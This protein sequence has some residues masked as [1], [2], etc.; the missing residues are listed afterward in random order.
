MSQLQS[1]SA[2][3]II[4]QNG[5]LSKLRFRVYDIIYQFGPITIKD[6]HAKLKAGGPIEI[7]STSP[8]FIELVRLGVIE[9]SGVTQCPITGHNVALYSVTGRLP[10]KLPASKLKARAVRELID[11]VRYISR[12][13]VVDERYF[14]TWRDR[15]KE[16][17]GVL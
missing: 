3:N 6:V 5:L 7:N 11:H 9:E 17:L 2:Y 14:I 16:I 1:I 10:I 13:E 8:R 4:K 12:F 15:A